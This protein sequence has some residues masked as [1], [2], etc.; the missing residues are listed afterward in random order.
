[1]AAYQQTQ[2]GVV[3]NMYLTHPDVMN[4]A[5]GNLAAI[6][7]SA[8]VPIP[9]HV[10]AALTTLTAYI[11]VIDRVGG[12]N[13]VDIT[14]VEGAAGAIVTPHGSP[15]YA[16][17]SQAANIAVD[18]GRTIGDFVIKAAGQIRTLAQAVTS[19]PAVLTE[20]ALGQPVIA[21]VAG[22]LNGLFG[23]GAPPPSN[24][25]TFGAV[26][27]NRTNPQDWESFVLMAVDNGQVALLSWQGFFSAQGGGGSSVYA[28]RSAVQDWEHWTL[29]RND[30]G[31]LSFRTHDN[32]HYLG[33]SATADSSCYADQWQIAQQPAITWCRFI[34][35]QLPAGHITLRASTGYVSVQP[36][37]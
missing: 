10:L 5:A 26:K 18:V 12:N 35:G 19:E 30:D 36:N 16:W 22:L 27:A 31:T 7:G 32:G 11:V 3:Y 15:A 20:V 33:T 6:V 24:P 17:L 23:Q 2:N 21:A 4:L 14:G 13:G 37:A 34:L 9:L 25:N 28:N 29:I 8:I 1:M